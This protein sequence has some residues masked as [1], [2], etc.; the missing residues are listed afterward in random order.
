MNFDHDKFSKVAAGIQSIVT[1]TGLIIAGVWVVYTFWA[2]GATNKARAEIA[3]LEQAAFEQP[4]L[5]ITVTSA[6]PIAEQAPHKPRL[7]LAI[8]FENTGK[9]AVEFEPPKLRARQIEPGAEEPAAE[10]INVTATV[11]VLA[12]G[13]EVQ[14]M[15]SRVLRAGQV[16]TMI[17]SAQVARPGSYFVQIE[18]NYH[19]LKL[20]DGAFRIS[21]DQM[22]QALEQA[23][24]SAK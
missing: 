24:I 13:G 21:N 12:D 5:Q 23:L 10:T 4:I 17:I 9:R 20:V 3:A 8:R 19:G 18:T 7:D 15:P 1:T 14:A 2:L 11:G 22:I 16:R 6:A